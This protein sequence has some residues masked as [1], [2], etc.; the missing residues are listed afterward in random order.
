MRNEM[1][2]ELQGATQRTRLSL[3][4]TANEI[5]NEDLQ[6]FMLETNR[7]GFLNRLFLALF[8]HSEA[9]IDEEVDRK[10]RYFLSVLEANKKASKLQNDAQ[11]EAV[12]NLLAE[13]YRHD[14]VEKYTTELKKKPKAPEFNIRL[15]KDVF[16]MLYSGEINWENQNAYRTVRRYL[17]ALIESYAEKPVC[18]RELVFF[19]D[20]VIQ[21]RQALEAKP[22]KR[23]GMIITLRSASG[24]AP[25][26]NTEKQAGRVKADERKTGLLKE[27]IVIPYCLET[28]KDNNYYYL[29]GLSRPFGK[30]DM[31]MLPS[32]FRL[33][34]I[35][36]V[37]WT[38]L[39]QGMSDADAE[40][41]QKR[42]D[43]RGIQYVFAGENK[44]HGDVVVK[45]TEEGM[46]KYR[47]VLHN[48][49]MFSTVKEEKDG[50]IR[51]TFGC[52]YEQVMYYFLQFGKD[53]VVISPDMLR[54]RMEST[55]T[56]AAEAYKA[57]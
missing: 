28:D 13:S 31:K 48:R 35:E 21:F 25:V 56:Q 49:P 20:N 42:I 23:S 36:S 4:V 17:E 7:T 5:I 30:R 47:Q 8:H 3:S 53:A 40:E 2:L 34:R 41:I 16:I 19:A 14:L 57:K 26:E 24:A 27:Y 9:C 37:R 10:K 52:S 15:N 1:P 6:N 22:K 54:E 50:S 45:L 18:E 55:Y 12:A 44:D 29:A 32:S 39:E 43:E 33:S 38:D 46:R 51:M 11:I